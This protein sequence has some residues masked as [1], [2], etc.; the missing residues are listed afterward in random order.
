MN[1]E[2]CT[3][4]PSMFEQLHRCEPTSRC[5]YTQSRGNFHTGKSVNT[6][7][8]GTRECTWLYKHCRVHTHLE[9]SLNLTLDLKKSLNF[10]FAWWISILLFPLNTAN[11]T[12]F[13]KN[14]RGETPFLQLHAGSDLRSLQA[15][16]CQKGIWVSDLCDTQEKLI[17]AVEMLLLNICMTLPH[18]S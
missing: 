1:G 15:W 7:E 17:D 14:I 9:K 4:T 8:L 10:I 18:V 2:Y 11:S 12:L 5:G 6:G 3:Q 13:T 16:S